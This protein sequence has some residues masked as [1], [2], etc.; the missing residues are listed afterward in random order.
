MT[1]AAALQEAAERGLAA[2]AELRL[3]DARRSLV[4]VSA[5]ALVLAARDKAPAS[6]G[7]TPAPV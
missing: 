5:V 4:T 2:L 3:E 1:T 6:E 7:G